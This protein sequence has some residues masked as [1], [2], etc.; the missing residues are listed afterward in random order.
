MDSKVTKIELAADIK[1]IVYMNDYVDIKDIIGSKV[2]RLRTD[3]GVS[4]QAIADRSGVFRTYISRLESGKAN[5]TITVL[6]A[7]ATSLK[8]EVAELFRE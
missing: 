4:Q 7:V 6:E 3:A 8:V 1:E 2:R 5:P